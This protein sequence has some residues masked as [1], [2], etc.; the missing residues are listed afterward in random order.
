[1][2]SITK[3][4]KNQD[5]LRHETTSITKKHVKKKN[6]SERKREE[7]RLFEMARLLHLEDFVKNHSENQT[8]FFFVFWRTIETQGVTR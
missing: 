2:V 6:Q 3:A 8:G 5:S 7:E 4:V 1:M